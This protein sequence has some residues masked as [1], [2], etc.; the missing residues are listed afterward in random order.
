MER[1]VSS[2]VNSD[3]ERLDFINIV[4]LNQAAQLDKE[5][6]RKWAVDFAKCE[7]SDIIVF[8][9]TI[10]MD[11][12]NRHDLPDSLDYTCACEWTCNRMPRKM[13]P[14][15]VEVV[16]PKPALAIAFKTSSFIN[17]FQIRDLEDFRSNMCPEN[18][19][20]GKEHRAFHFFSIEAEDSIEVATNQ[21]F[22]TASQALHN[23]YRFMAKAGQLDM[24]YEKVRFFSVVATTAEFRLRVHRATKLSKGRILP[25]YPLGFHFDEIHIT[26]GW[27]SKGE[28]SQIVHNILVNHGIEILKPVLQES[29]DNVLTKLENER[30]PNRKRRAEDTMEF[31]GS[32]RARVRGLDL[33]GTGSLSS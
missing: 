24:F 33:E 14:G 21:N 5:E 4:L 20:L 3:P 15:A 29:A 22:N 13:R 19:N 16:M 25:D 8:Q 27:Y 31:F 30:I 23:I 26:T 17:V 6:E 11:L 32:Q 9:R 7:R 28:V 10:M 18:I 2:E 12:F 1:N